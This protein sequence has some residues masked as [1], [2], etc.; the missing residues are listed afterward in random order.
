MSL[1]IPSVVRV[2]RASFVPLSNIPIVPW[3]LQKY[4]QGKVPKA[5]VNPKFIRGK[6]YP[7]FLQKSDVRLKNLACFFYFY[8]F[9]SDAKVVGNPQQVLPR[10][11]SFWGLKEVRIVSALCCRFVSYDKCERST[12]YWKGRF[13][14]KI[15]NFHGNYLL[16]FWKFYII[17]SYL[18]HNIFIWILIINWPE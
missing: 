4:F 12:R 13:S 7:I 15:S 2:I 14:G 8:L 18:W 10:I 16:Y 17:C 6:T 5:L 1:L 9:Y 3:D 11:G